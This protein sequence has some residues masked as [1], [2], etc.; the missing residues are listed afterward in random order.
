M[1]LKL[2]PLGLI[3]AFMIGVATPVFA[4]EEPDISQMSERAIEQLSEN[5]DA[6]S[7]A[8][9]TMP[10]VCVALDA[11]LAENGDEFGDDNAE[12]ENEMRGKGNNNGKA[13][14]HGKDAADNGKGKGGGDD[15][16][17]DGA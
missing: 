12:D 4:Q 9:G 17:D 1:K 16:S 13:K 11:Y 2:K 5:C 14:G 8:S 7:N 15:T 10:A 3:P 6:H